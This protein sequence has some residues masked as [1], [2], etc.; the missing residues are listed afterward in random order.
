MCEICEK[1]DNRGCNE[2]DCLNA[3]IKG[4]DSEVNYNLINSL[5]CN[6]KQLEVSLMIVKILCL[7]N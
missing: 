4:L 1:P 6:L 2:N 7:T 3:I 5:K